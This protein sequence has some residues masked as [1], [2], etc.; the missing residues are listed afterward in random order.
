MKKILIAVIAV[1]LIIT[2]CPIMSVYAKNQT[3]EIGTPVEEHPELF[4]PRSLPTHGEGKIAVFLIE[5]P[6]FKNDKPY[7]TADYYDKIYFSGGSFEGVWADTTVA[8]FYREQ[9][10]GKLN[11]SG[12]V[13]DWYTAK[14]ERSYYNNKKAELVMEAAEHYRSQGVDFS[15]FDGNGDGIIDAVTYHFA[16][17]YSKNQDNPW[18]GGVNYG[19]SGGVGDIDG[20]K[21]TTIV[22][23]YNGAEQKDNWVLHTICH[24][25]MHSLGMPDLYGKTTFS[26]MG[27]NDLMS[28]NLQTI[29]PYTKMMLGWIDTVDVITSD[30]K[31]VKLLPYGTD[32]S[33]KVVIVTDKFNGLFDEFYIVAYREYT[34]SAVVWH[35][36]ARLNEDESAF[37]NN[38]Q[39]YDARPDK[40]NGHE[41]GN[42][43][44]PYLFIE[45][46]S[47]DPEF[48]YVFPTDAQSKDTAFKKDSVLGPDSL[49]SSDTHDGSYTGIKM[50]NFTTHKDE[51]LT[52]DVSF[53]NDSTPPVATTKENELLFNETVTVKFNE[54]IYEE[55]AFGDIKVTDLNGAPLEATVILPHYPHHEMEITFK[56]DG[57]ADGYKIVIP[58]NALRDSSG[59][60]IA[61]VTLTASAE[62]VFKPISDKQLP[63]IEYSRNNADAFFF[64]CDDSLVVITTL[65]EDHVPD[66]KLEFMRLDCNGNVI[67]HTI[68]DNPFVNSTITGTVCQASDGSYIFFCNDNIDSTQ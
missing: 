5:F 20:L 47:A 30:A 68:I 62:S 10:Y 32:K 40:N 46:L 53:V 48:N 64:N 35:I 8:D 60:G 19:F 18:Y 49:P 56:N 67:K 63:H 41:F 54:S 16:G 57:Y 4:L 25:L 1:M 21:L 22:Q 52:F 37:M 61:A 27:A 55:K 36:D 50:D 39:Y 24:E 13:F 51:Y 15:K 14:H 43:A 2:S 34:S 17:E 31:G 29:N 12:R 28:N 38:N 65:W 44:S 45:E 58:Q 66:A 59:N 42:E 3:F 33:G 26:L 7:A 11:L 23:V 9:S 6:D